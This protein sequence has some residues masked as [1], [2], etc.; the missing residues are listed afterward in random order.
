M[1]LKPKNRR[2]FTLVELLVVIAIIL[3]LT[4]MTFGLFKGATNA[5]RKAKAK[6][7][8]QAMKVACEIFRKNYGDYP[9]RAST[10]TTATARRELFDQLIGRRIVKA[11]SIANGGTDVELIAYNDP[12]LPTGSQG[13][14]M[15][16]LIEYGAISSNNDAG[17][18]L[19]D[20]TTG[21]PTTY[22]FQDAWGNAYDYRYRVLNPA[23]S[24]IQDPNTGV[25]VG[26][27]AIWKT[28]ACLIVGA[29]ANFVAPA[30]DGLPLA[31]NEYWD[32]SGASP[33]STTGVITSTYH[34]EPSSSGPF[35]A[36]NITSWEN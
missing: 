25:Y 32:D 3:I 18:A 29:G 2:G 11:F 34:D 21:T 26:N 24:A 4:A 31:D 30:A 16:P 14:V 12:R 6:G 10:G 35:R 15:K 33:M 28:S 36:D 19:T 7:D 8:I 17:W 9:C 22:Q 1:T 13:R 5:N 27:Y 20:W 23:G